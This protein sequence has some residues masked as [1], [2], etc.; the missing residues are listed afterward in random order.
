MSNLSSTYDNNWTISVTNS[1]A[2]MEELQ[3]TKGAFLGNGKIGL[4][5]ALDCIGLKQSLIGTCFDFDE[6]GSYGNN[7]MHAFDFTRIKLFDHNRGPETVSHTQFMNQSLNMFTGIATTIFE[8]TNITTS[9]IVNVAYDIYPVRHLPYC[10]V[11]SVTFTPLQDMACLDIYHEITCGENICVE[12]YNNNTIYNELV[13]TTNGVYVLTGNGHFKSTHKPVAI[14]SCYTAEDWSKFNVVGF[15]RYAKDKNTCYQKITLSNIT[16][17]SSYVLNI[18]STEMSGYD[19]KKPV[20]EV[21]RITVNIAKVTQTSNQM[22]ALRQKHV[23]AWYNMWKS[24]I[25]IEPK[26]GITT[27]EASDFSSV[28]RL[29][30][31]SMYNLWSSVREGVRT[32]INPSSL[33]AID[34]YGTLFWDGDLWFLPTLC[35]FRPDIAKNVLEA[36]YRSIDK[37]IQLA[38][39]Y[40]YTG[41]KYPY[42]HDTTGYLQAPYWDLNGPMH[43]FNTA[44][45]S[46]GIWNYYRISSDKDWL[47]NKGYTMMKNN[48]DFFASRVEIDNDNSYHFRNVVSF[49][50]KVADDNALTNYLIKTALR[51]TIEAS[52]ELNIIGSDSWGQVY[53][54]IDMPFFNNDP[55]GTVMLDSSSQPSDTYKFLE[56]LIP[57][58]TFYSDTYLATNINRDMTTIESNLMFYQNTVQPGYTTNPLNNLILAWMN[59]SLTNSGATYPALF[60][61]ALLNVI[62]D[63][64][65]GLW[66]DLN[67]DNDANGYHDNSLGSMVALMLMTTLGTLRITGIVTETR[68]YAEAMG[69]FVDNT[70]SMP[71]TW[72]SM[73]LTGVGAC[74]DT[75]NVLNMNYYS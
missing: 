52:Y 74:G 36:R 66:G 25:T 24:N 17:N 41:S 63:N 58:L 19:F 46:I 26:V 56:M 45:V 65:V 32:E 50:N 30:R 51:Y 37:A 55:L 40:G 59:A 20:D 44:L 22:T 7:I 71:T 38:A 16:A 53:Y 70:S 31:Y 73:R 72:K 2:S 11:Q 47:R 42:T 34:T 75:Y 5:L 8:V 61:T 43:I 33:T 57:L 23:N 9:N 35:I 15:N 14:A 13:S 62:N 49:D 4:T 10:T 3:T 67:M 68:F 6:D 39:G 18:L 60:N 48:A 12:D 28:K 69:F 1:N 27:Q 29:I 64:A 54:N 21:K